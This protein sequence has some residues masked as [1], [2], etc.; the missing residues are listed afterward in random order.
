MV[1]DLTGPGQR[2]GEFVNS[3]L[4][5]LINGFIVA[6]GVGGVG[7]SGRAR[8]GRLGK[9]AGGLDGHGRRLKGGFG[10]REGLWMHAR[11]TRRAPLSGDAS[12][13]V[14]ARATATGIADGELAPRA[15]PPGKLA[16]SQHE[17][18]FSKRRSGPS[19]LG[20]GCG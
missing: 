9:R 15:S 10:T 5:L 6:C 17:K 16:W 14:A 19:R 13:M 7:G 12:F 4:N 20:H 2:P 11:G 3:W 18:F 8:G 1:D